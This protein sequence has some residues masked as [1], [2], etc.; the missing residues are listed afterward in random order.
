MGL[1]LQTE[2]RFDGGPGGVFFAFD[3]FDV[4]LG[5]CDVGVAEESA[6]FFDVVAS[7]FAKHGGSVAEGVRMDGDWIEAGAAAVALEEGADLGG[8]DGLG[9][10]IVG[11]RVAGGIGALGDAG[12]AAAVGGDG[13]EYEISS[14]DSFEATG[15][16]EPGF[17]AVPDAERHFVEFVFFAFARPAVEHAPVFFFEV[18]PAE[19]A[20]LGVA[21]TGGEIT[22]EEGVVAQALDG[23][24]VDGGEDGAGFGGGEVAGFAVGVDFG[25][26]GFGS[27]RVVNDEGGFL[28]VWTADVVVVDEVG[29][30]G[31]DGSDAGVDGLFGETAF[32]EV[33]DPVLDDGGGNGPGAGVGEGEEVFDGKFVDAAG[34]GG[35]AGF[36]EAASAF[37]PESFGVGEFP[38]GWLG[39]EYIACSGYTAGEDEVWGLNDGDNGCVHGLLLGEFVQVDDVLDELVDFGEDGVGV[40]VVGIGV[41]VFDDGHDFFEGAAVIGQGI[42]DEY[43]AWVGY[44]PGGFELVR[45]AAGPGVVG[46]EGVLSEHETSGVVCNFDEEVVLDKLVECVAVSFGFKGDKGGEDFAHFV[47]EFTVD[48]VNE[49]GFE[50]GN[51]DGCRFGHGVLPS[52]CDLLLVDGWLGVVYELLCDF[53]VGMVEFGLLCAVGLL[54]PFA[55]DHAD[56]GRESMSTQTLFFCECFDSLNVLR[57]ESNRLSNDRSFS[58]NAAPCCLVRIK[59]YLKT[60]IHKVII[61]VNRHFIGI[62]RISVSC[63]LV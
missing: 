5:D 32:A 54:L 26:Q 60:I 27:C 20:E 29:I 33:G 3:G 28:A 47:A 45:L 38:A 31:G 46:F 21:A 59:K 39:N 15:G 8:G 35:A 11:N 56:S 30:V 53:D 23:G 12:D 36:E 14:L 55:D 18:A 50:I 6:N 4:D 10:W 58:H 9:G 2:E 57:F 25:A 34:V 17:D 43:I 44:N 7:F 24:A 51:R 52:R 1:C 19:R 62:H 49:A 41:V 22:E 37:L 40:F 16:F 42:G 13:G 63:R 48:D 61:V